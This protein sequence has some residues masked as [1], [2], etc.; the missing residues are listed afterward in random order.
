MS[1]SGPSMMRKLTRM[2]QLREGKLARETEEN[3]S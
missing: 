3:L 1:V 2:E